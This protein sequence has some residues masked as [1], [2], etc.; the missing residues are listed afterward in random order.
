VLKPAWDQFD[1][2]GA[3]VAI[4]QASF[5]S[6]FA[7]GL[8]YGAPARGSWNIVHTGMLLPEAHQIFICA[9]GCLRGV[10]LTAAEMNALDRFSTVA[11]R[12]NNV[13][14]GDMEE[15]IIEGVTDVLHKLPKLPPAVLVYTS[16]I[17][18]FMG[19]DLPRVYRVLRER[20]PQVAFTDCYMNPI[21]RKSGITPDELD[22]RQLYSLL[23]PRPI[24]PKSV[25][26]IGGDLAIDSTSEL[27][28]LVKDAGFRLREI[29]SCRSYAEYQEMAESFLN[30][31]T[32]PAAKAAV[33]QL[34]HRLGQK[35]LYLPQCFGYDEIDQ[36][37]RRLAEALGTTAPDSAQA[38][39]AADAALARARDLIGNTPIAIDYTLTF[40]PLSL[41]RLL[42]EHGFKV[43]QL[44]ADSFI[45]EE[46]DDFDWLQQNLPNLKLGAT[47]HVKRRMLPRQN[48][49]V[50]CLALGQKA[51]YFTG[52]DYF[53]NVV[54]G[55][56]MYGYDGI[57]R[58][59]GLMAEAF[60]APKDVKK[61]IQV[62]GLGCDCCL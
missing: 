18:H 29:T 22:R 46:K 48:G 23:E 4:G 17:H 47:T 3:A 60:L 31:Y 1:E 43:T 62:K 14:D 42:A 30:L 9:S 51:A 25:N 27:C 7:S 19:C 36:N 56:G 40:R 49:G 11:I 15:L 52:T 57:R 10:V 59:A 39:L 13:L 24:D 55:G 37:Q 38:R 54:E 2:S 26:I 44:F 32:I 20:F 6:P 34:E 33:V 5:P 45:A 35:Y 50:P 16:C 41:A 8:E 28:R 12:E 53:V 61:L 58:L 21:M